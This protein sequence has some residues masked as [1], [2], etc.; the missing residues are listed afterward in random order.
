MPPGF[1]EV[2]REDGCLDRR[3]VVP[4]GLRGETSPL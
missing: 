4:R 2:H 3:T 1:Q